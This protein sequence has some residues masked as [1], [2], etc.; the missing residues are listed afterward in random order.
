MVLA[1][2]VVAA[3]AHA[4][5]LFA[6][7]YQDPQNGTYFNNLVLNRVDATVNFDWGTGSPDSSI[8]VDDFSVR[9][10]GYVVPQYSEV[11]T[12]VSRTDDGV[13]VWVDGALLIDHWVNQ[14]PTEW[15]G[16]TSAALQAGQRYAI[17][18]EWYER[19]GGAVAQLSWESASQARAIIPE[20]ALVPW[21]S[22]YGI[23]PAKLV[24]EGQRLELAVSVFNPLTELDF[25]W[26]R[27][28]NPISGATL[29]V[30]SVASASILND[31]GFYTCEVTDAT[32]HLSVVSPMVY[33]KV[34]VVGSVPA[35]STAGLVL[36]TLAAVVSG[37]VRM[38]AR[39]VS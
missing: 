30:Y 8:A 10:S 14:A 27:N 2:V 34:Y 17:V 12:F 32:G 3:C 18:M 37:I 20:S 11:Y 7:Y 24:E 9:W 35:V 6:T 28:G 22:G 21:I 38:R 1:A 5:G 16:T 33:Q 36:L 4:G 23:S 19:G 39:I 25:Q 29:Q 13:R 26:Y 31:E 15:S